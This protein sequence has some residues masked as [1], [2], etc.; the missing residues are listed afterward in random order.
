MAAF[1]GAVPRRD[2]L[3]TVFLAGIGAAVAPAMRGVGVQE[4]FGAESPSQIDI[5]VSTYFGTL[6]FRKLTDFNDW[7]VATLV[8]SS[9]VR[10]NDQFHPIP[11]LA[12][13]W[14]TDDTK[15]V[16]H[17]R[18]AKFHDGTPVSSDDVKA[19]F[20][21]VLDPNFGA[22]NRPLFAAIQSV[23]APD[24]R[25]VTM[26]LSAPNPAL[27]AF[28]PWV[29]IVPR[30]Y[31]E[32]HP[33]L[34]ATNPIG[35]GPYKFVSTVPQNVTVLDAFDDFWGGRPAFR[36]LQYRIVPDATTRTV[37]VQS[38]NADMATEV[39][40]S[41]VSA[42]MRDPKLYTV[43]VPPNG[44]N[45]L[46]LNLQN[47]VLADLKVR[48]AIAYAI[49]RDA[50]N[51]AVYYG[52]AQ[53][54]VSPV[55]PTSWGFDPHVTVYNYDQGKA[56]QLLTEAGRAKGV[57]VKLTCP[58]SQEYTQIGTILKQQ[59]GAVGIDVD[60]APQEFTV[61]VSQVIKG[62]IGDLL[63]G[64]GWGQQMDPE[65]HMYRQ[66]LST[67]EPPHGYN[68]VRYSN[69]E[70]DKVLTDANSTLDT[71]RRKALLGRAQ[72]ILTRDLPYIY[73]FN[74]PEYW[75]ISARVTGITAPAPMD[76]R[77]LQLA[78]RAKRAS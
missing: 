12:E 56:K 37:E 5:V 43:Q 27:M 48:Q 59:L 42:V 35:S 30:R 50:I 77:F 6:D 60:L 3:R 15:Y 19:T 53:K 74:V 78:M 76:R 46:G 32:Q 29:G 22:P 70:L 23:E 45:Y 14:E 17:L 21:K 31:A 68:F 39:A 57:T 8:Y 41:D 55:I 1:T 2:L 73:L 34:V 33:E 40:F 26:H 18:Q 58:N 67:N 28:L 36:R 13:R 52:L 65:Q 72:Q 49:D 7:R 71:S 61:L 75:A 11:D 16:F 10:N 51:K 62:Q 25:T 47:P 64:F 63:L 4:A 44:F 38:G 24:P 9:L 20:D 66:F 69:A 54:A